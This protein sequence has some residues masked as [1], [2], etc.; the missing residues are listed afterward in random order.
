MGSVFH[1]VPARAGLALPFSVRES[2]VSVGLWPSL[3]SSEGC[4]QRVSSDS[5][6]RTP[7]QRG[8]AV[9]E[10]L[11]CPPLV[12]PGPAPRLQLHSPGQSPWAICLVLKPLS[13][14]ERPVARPAPSEQPESAVG[15]EAT[16]RTDY[17]LCLWD[18]AHRP[19]VG[20][21]R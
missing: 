8:V 1:T 6:V 9:P 21:N 20:A 13:V 7:G 18:L 11:R 5:V 14:T 12:G 19:R 4:L 2:A 16:H 17:Q 3:P 10:E 15:K